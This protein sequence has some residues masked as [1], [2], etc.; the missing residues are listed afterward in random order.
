MSNYTNTVDSMGDAA[1]CKALLEKTLV[2]ITDTHCTTIGGYAFYKFYDLRKAIFENATRI[3]QYAFAYC[4]KLETVEIPLAENVGYFSFYECTKLKKADFPNVKSVNRYAF[5]GS[6]ALETLVLR[7]TTMATLLDV[8]ALVDTRIEDGKGYIYVPSALI[9]SYKAD[10]KWSTYANQFR[11]LEHYTVDGTITG[12]LD[13]NRCIVRFF[14]GDTLLQTVSVPYGGNALYTGDVPVS[15]KDASYEFKGW[16]PSPV[17][18]TGDLDCYAEFNEPLVLNDLSWAEISAIS[19]EGTGADY[20]AIGDTKA[21]ALKGTVG[22]L[23]L[24]ATYNVYI[25]GFDHNS[26]LEGNGIHFGT[27]KTISG[28]NVALCDAS[29]NTRKT[30]GTKIFNV[31]HWGYDCYGGWAG[32]DMRY[33]ILGSTD[34]PPSGYGAKAVSGRTG[35]NPSANCTSTPVPNTLMAAL[36]VDLRAVL[37]PMTKYTDN[38]G[39]HTSETQGVESDVTATIDYLPLLAE[40][41]VLGTRIDVSTKANLFERKKQAQYD[42]YA[43]VGTPKKF[44]HSS[45]DKAIHYWQRSIRK[46]SNALFTTVTPDSIA[47]EA[48]VDNSLGISPIFKV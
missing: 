33:D 39:G 10:S 31:N 4:S 20:F 24:D 27:F 21:V 13:T 9:D 25:I 44:N 43:T 11:V 6:T 7:S 16:N 47:S 23:E 12:E 36:P 5:N 32:C 2:E 46:G 17:N 38:V 45:T 15:E 22:T 37:K 41:E 28:L 8:N 40:H 1:I 30:D 42:Y 48:R 35:N 18:I 14:N 3:E 29:Y 19:A 34:I 26:E